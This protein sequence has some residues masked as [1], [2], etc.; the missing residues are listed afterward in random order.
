MRLG[1]G[2]LLITAA[3][4]GDDGGNLPVGGGGN[5][6]GFTF[7]DSNNGSGSGGSDGSVGPD[8]AVTPIDAPAIDGR[9][10]LLTDAR[11]LN[12]CAS[13]GAGG[14]TV[15]L[16]TGVALTAD[17]GSFTIAGQSG[18]GL[19]WQISGPNIV[20][21]FEVLADYFIPAMPRTMF[22]PLKGANGVPTF[23]QLVGVDPSL[24]LA[25]ELAQSDTTPGQETDYAW[26]EYCDAFA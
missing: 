23:R 6:G 8:G 21:S 22:D 25:E 14:L 2:L 11:K 3:A 18:Q 16:G 15:R 20:S 5:D 10:C 9:V 26:R 4:C 24:S 12:Q 1:I 13:T 17:D 19:V 7:V